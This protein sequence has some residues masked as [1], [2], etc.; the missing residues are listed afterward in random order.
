MKRFVVSILLVA[1]L[2]AMA[3]VSHAAQTERGRPALEQLLPEDIRSKRLGELTLEDFEATRNRVNLLTTPI[4]RAG[5]SALF[6]GLGQFRNG[7]V[8]KGVLHAAVFLGVKG[9]TLLFTWQNL[10]ADLRNT[11]TA[12]DWVN[13][14][15]GVIR[16]TLKTT[17]EAQ[18]LAD[19]QNS[20]VILA[21][22]KVLTGVWRRF[23][24][25]DAARVAREQLGIEFEFKFR[26][27]GRH[28]GLR[29]RMRF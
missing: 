17:F 29:W 7:E 4:R 15:V 24:S 20:L 26:P 2:M 19:F 5:Q 22:G 9:A 27:F 11:I 6:P 14:P 28:R 18:S 1:S 23:S 21:A 10:P 8:G 12:I 3:V 25:R 13:T 16:D